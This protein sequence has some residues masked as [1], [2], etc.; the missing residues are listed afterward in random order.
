MP[1]SIPLTQI[2]ARLLG[3]GLGFVRAAQHIPG[4]LR[5]ALIGSLASTKQAP[6][7][8]D[9]LVSVADDCDLSALAVIGRCGRS[10]ENGHALNPSRSPKR[11]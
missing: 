7:D 6:K 5:I 11:R 9:F 10:A 2:R 4:V 1:A 8:I 3:D